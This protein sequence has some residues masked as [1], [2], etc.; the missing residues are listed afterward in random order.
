M[1]A[2]EAKI[3]AYQRENRES[4]MQNEARKVGPNPAPLSAGLH[5]DMK[6]MSYPLFMILGNRQRRRESVQIVY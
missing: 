1:D 5:A 3:T 6:L 4:I 2:M